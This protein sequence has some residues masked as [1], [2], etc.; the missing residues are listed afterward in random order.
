MIASHLLHVEPDGAFSIVAIVWRPG[1]RTSIHDHLTWCV[2][3][4]VHGAETEELFSLC[5]NGAR[6]TRVGTTVNRVG[7]VVGFAP[8]GDIHR[9]ANTGSE[10]A[11]SIHI[12]GS[13][14][15]RVGSSVRRSYDLP[16]VEGLR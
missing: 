4:V 16:V 3:G 13:D 2:V 1:Q 9:V 10:N 7:E 5:E 12:Y 15:R 11:I 6:L 8:P 14:I